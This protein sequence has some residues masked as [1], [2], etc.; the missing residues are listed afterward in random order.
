MLKTK[1]LLSQTTHNSFWAAEVGLVGSKRKAVGGEPMPSILIP[2]TW[3]P[4]P[5]TFIF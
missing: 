4:T 5:K 1:D 3:H 2:Y